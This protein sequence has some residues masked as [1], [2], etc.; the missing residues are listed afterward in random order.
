VLKDYYADNQC[1]MILNGAMVLSNR[2]TKSMSE[3]NL[4][5][6]L[7]VNKKLK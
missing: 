7:M 2:P 1:S 4:S 5:A 6:A 3:T